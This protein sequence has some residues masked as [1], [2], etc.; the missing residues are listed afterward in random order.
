MQTPTLPPSVTPSHKGPRFW[1]WLVAC[2]LV[3]ISCAAWLVIKNRHQD[4]VAV[5]S[6]KYE[7]I[8]DE[9]TTTEVDQI[10]GDYSATTTFEEADTAWFGK[11]LTKRSSFYTEYSV[12]PGNPECKVIMV[13]FD[14]DY[15][16]VD[17]WIGA[18]DW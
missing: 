7:L 14:K 12:L 5:F 9:M 11:P 8:R 1:L 16:V 13:F 6:Q 17:K 2:S 15:Q 4:P 18:F 10:L 3:L